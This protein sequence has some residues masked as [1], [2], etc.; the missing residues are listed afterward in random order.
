MAFPSS[1]TR[2]GRVLAIAASAGL[3]L[4]LAA[5]GGTSSSGGDANS[6]GGPKV[7]TPEILSNGTLKICASYG[8]PPNIYVDESGEPVGAEIDIANAMAKNLGLKTAFAEYNFSG[9]VPALQ[10]KQCDVIM[11][12]LYIKPEREKVAS[13]VPYLESGSAVLVAKKDP[14]GITGFNETLCGKKVIAITGASGAVHTEE[15][16][17]ECVAAGKPAIS[18]TLNDNITSL[19]Q[20]LAGQADAF[21]DTAELAGYY[22]KKG[23]FT[24]VGEPFGGI[25]IGAATLKSNTKLHDALQTSFDEVEKSGEYTKILEKWGLQGNAVKAS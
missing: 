7:A 8:T 19:Q 11:S 15:K 21:I 24:L 9:L 23:D 22:E 10:A 13:F 1:I 17:K 25:T 16:S 2:A 12:S 3:A 4:S 6:E 5:C 18:I 20:L 14:K